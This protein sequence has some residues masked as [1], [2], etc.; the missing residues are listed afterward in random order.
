MRFQFFLY[1]RMPCI[2]IRVSV[3]V[4][5][6]HM[7]DRV[8]VA[9]APTSAVCVTGIFACMRDEARVLNAEK[10]PV[11]PMTTT[12]PNLVQTQAKERG[13]LGSVLLQRLNAIILGTSMSLS[14]LPVEGVKSLP[15][16]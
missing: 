12:T 7:C 5:P 3:A 2:A 4:A 1:R 14:S 8:S 15:I 10:C 11:I 6:C 9:V 13:L 16:A